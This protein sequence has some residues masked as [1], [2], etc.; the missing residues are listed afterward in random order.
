DRYFEIFSVN[1][2]DML[3]MLNDEELQNVGND[4]IESH[5]VSDLITALPSNSGD[6]LPV[7]WKG[8]SF[9]YEQL[10]S[11]TFNNLGFAYTFNML[12]YSELFY[13]S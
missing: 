12:D 7:T 3:N 4:F 13:N 9:S 1:C 6:I 2:N 10:L 8:K 11:G 5:R